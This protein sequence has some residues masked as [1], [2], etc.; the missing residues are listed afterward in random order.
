MALQ[1]TRTL[2]NS[3]KL[4]NP[5]RAPRV[6]IIG[7][8]VVGMTSALQLLNKGYKVTVVAKE[9][10]SPVSSGKRITS[11][12]AGALWEWPPAVCGR[13]TDEKSLDSYGKF[14]ELAMN[15]KETGAYLR[16]SIF[17][18]K[19]KVNDLPK[20]LEKMD[21]LSHLPGFRHDAKLIEETAV[22]TDTGVVDAYQHMAPMV[23]TITYMQWLY[24]QCREKGC[25]FVQDE[26]H[27]LL[28]DQAE[29][30]KRKYKAQL[31]FNCSGLNAKELAGDEDV[32]PLRGVIVKVKND[33]SLMPK[34]NHSMCISLI[35]DID[36]SQKE[37]Q[38]FVFILP[39]GDD[40]LWLGGMVQPNQ[41]DKNLTLDYPPI[42]RMFEKVK[43][44]YAPLRNYGDE[45]V[46]EVLVGLR[47]ARKGNV[48][49][50]WDPVCPSLLH[51]YGHGGS[52]VTF[53]WGCAIEASAMVD[54][55]LK[56]PQIYF[57]KL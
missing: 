33:G 13:H 26:I 50:E 15:P 28:R 10:A 11:E 32:Y 24:K 57:S 35:E 22:N 31:I 25:H 3:M 52:G 44:F 7:G 53:S 45:D 27:G 40:K 5:Q 6:L 17:Y 23:D 47:P 2:D 16:Q 42:R 49:L 29:D 9:Y 38:S 30:L 19:D 56:M 8:G 51:N 46:E 41:W 18:F 4:K 14:M 48:R 1:F 34:L 21:E 20:Q 12:I 36:E 54:R 37:G 43:E 55:V 39:R